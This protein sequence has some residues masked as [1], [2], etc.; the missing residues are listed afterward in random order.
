MIMKTAQKIIYVKFTRL[1]TLDALD[2]IESFWLLSVAESKSK[3][4]RRC[5]FIREKFSALNLSLEP[6]TDNQ[7]MSAHYCRL[8]LTMYDH[9]FAIF[10]GPREIIMGAKK[11]LCS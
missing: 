3:Q 4:R 6:T 8:S 2:I 1:F 7:S 11:W 5:R 10:K 9:R